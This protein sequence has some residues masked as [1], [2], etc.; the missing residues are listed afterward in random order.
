MAAYVKQADQVV[1]ILSKAEAT[2]FNEFI[3]FMQEWVDQEEVEIPPRVNHEKEKA[4]DRA[5]RALDVACNPGSRSGAA[6]Q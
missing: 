6:I 1:L 3:G 4:R 2:A 5:I